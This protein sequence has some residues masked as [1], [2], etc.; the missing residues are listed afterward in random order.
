MNLLHLFDHSLL[1]RRDEIALEWQGENSTFGDIETRSNRVANALRARGFE[2]GDRLCV[3]LANRVEL[4]DLYLACVKLGV[5]FV[6]INILY[7]DREISHIVA[8]AEPKLVIT[9]GEWR[10]PSTLRSGEK[11]KPDGSRHLDGDTPAALVY[12]S[13]TTGQSK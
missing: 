7:R 5:I 1:G 8:D 12:T 4:I 3:Y 9:K 13:G 2:K 10:E 11:R 6:P